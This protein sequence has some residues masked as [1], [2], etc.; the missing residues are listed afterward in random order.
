VEQQ[1]FEEYAR[2]RAPELTRFAFLLTVDW[3]LA[4]DLV[5]EALITT[6]LKWRRIAGM[7]HPDAYVRRV[8]TRRFLYWRRKR[9]SGETPAGLDLDALQRHGGVDAAETLASDDLVWQALS[10]L[11]RRQRAVLA[12]RYYEDLPDDRIA[13]LLGCATST[14]RVH[15]ARGVATLRARLPELL[16]DSGSQ[17]VSENLK[18]TLHV[19]LAGGPGTSSA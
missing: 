15:A 6:H 9:S 4:Q 12:L 13:D 19:S 17:S 1:S 2:A 18:R 16:V 14:V 3:A 11:P 10:Q 5:Q 8:L 7:E